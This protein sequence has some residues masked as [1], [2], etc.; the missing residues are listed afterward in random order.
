MGGAAS[1]AVVRVGLVS[2]TH[3][4]LDPRVLAVFAENGPLAAIMHAGDIGSDPDVLWELEA[5]AHVTAVLGNCDHAIPGFALA[6]VARTSVAGVRLLAIH[7]FG[8]LGTIP[9][10]VDVVVCGHT[11]SPSVTYHGDVLVVNPGSAS[12]RRRMPSRSVAIL[13]LV[14]GERPTARILPLDDVE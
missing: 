8:D 2:D 10:D 7:D 11:H 12:Q 1:R 6:G 5:V 14:E 4:F 3:G 13:E 9:D